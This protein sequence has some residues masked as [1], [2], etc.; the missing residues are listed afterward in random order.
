MVTP[1]TY[2]APLWLPGGHLQTIWASR[3]AKAVPEQ[4]TVPAYVRERWPTPDGDFIDVDIQ[5]AHHNGQVLAENAAP[6]L[7]LFHGL[8]GHSLSPYARAFAW[9]AYQKGWH[10]AVP[11]FRGCSGEINHAPRA[12]HSGDHEELHWILQRLRQRA[13]SALRIAGISLGGNALLRWA[14]AAGHSAQATASAVCAVCAPMDLMVCGQ[15][16]G[17]GLNRHIYTRVFLA[18]MKPK[19][20]A[21]LQQ[22]PRLF[23][24]DALVRA[25][26]LYEFDDVF[27]AP[28][29]GF[30][31]VE[32]Y[33][34]RASSL[35]ALNDIQ[36]PAL[37][38]HA[39]NDP[40]VPAASIP[41]PEGLNSHIC[42]WQ[43][44]CGGHV[45][46]TSGKA[47]GHGLAMPQAVMRWFQSQC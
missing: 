7:V 35:P 9:V 18:T 15:A 38:I 46:F 13:Q 8:E 29:H 37:V 17:Q 11:H 40:F 2:R 24:R 33:W 26:T 12:Y 1:W 36:I 27:T 28:L 41:K 30:K 44:R 20:L 31:G 39:R 47:P 4:A 21:K 25:K 45:G 23:E 42:L 43:P 34:R 32:D 14:Q 6:W 22:F 10:F 16:L 3:V 5:Y 19:A